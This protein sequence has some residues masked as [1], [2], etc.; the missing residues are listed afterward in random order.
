MC[1]KLGLADSEGG[2]GGSERKPPVYRDG[3]RISRS[4]GGVLRTEALRE[5]D[6][7]M[8]LKKGILERS[9]EFCCCW[10]GVDERD[11]APL[12]LLSDSSASLLVSEPVLEGSDD[13]ACCS[14]FFM[15]PKNLSASLTASL[16]STPAKATTMRSGR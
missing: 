16:C 3:W 12:L 4:E 9:L 1:V 7:E 15:S 11:E 13:D 10:G 8:F 5:A 14:P 2:C 6:V